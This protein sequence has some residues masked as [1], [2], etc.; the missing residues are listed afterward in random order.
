MNY[1]LHPELQVIW[2]HSGIDFANRDAVAGFNRHME[3]VGNHA[4]PPLRGLT[5]FMNSA[6][7]KEFR[8]Y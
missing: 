7:E 6:F 2:K 1:D 3:Q 5:A 8:R 4:K